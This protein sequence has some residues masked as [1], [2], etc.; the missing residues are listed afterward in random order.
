MQGSWLLH[1]RLSQ[2]FEKCV[3]YAEY[4][5]KINLIPNVKALWFSQ[6]FLVN[7]WQ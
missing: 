4:A 3:K 5:V 2:S 1:E 6:V 7:G